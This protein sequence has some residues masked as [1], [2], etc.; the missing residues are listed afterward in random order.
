MQSVAQAAALVPPDSLLLRTISPAPDPPGCRQLVVVAAGGRT[1][2]WSP[3]RVA[4]HLLEITGGRIVQA[5]FH[6]AAP[7][8]DRAIAAAANQLGWP[9]IACPAL[10]QQ[11]GRSA[12]PIRNRQMLHQ[13]IAQLAQLALLPAGAALLVV[14]FP[15][16]PGT[17]SLVQLTRS[18]Q[19]RSS[20]SIE[21]LT[22]R[23]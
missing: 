20:L 13:A 5:L 17:A 23:A 7:G 15:G 11:H 12:G 21:L 22:I 16:G 8:A 2:A 14:A 3:S 18:L 19:A 9:V 10:W 6:G 1:L 4:V